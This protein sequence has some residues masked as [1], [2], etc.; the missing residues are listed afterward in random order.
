MN[1][2][3]R[4]LSAVAA[5]FIA[6]AFANAAGIGTFLPGG[7]STFDARVTTPEEFL[8]YGV[9]ERFAE[10]SDVTGYMNCL[11]GCSD[12]VSVKYFGRTYEKRPF[13]QVVITSAANQA[14]LEEIRRQHLLLTD[15]NASA[16]MDITRM[17]VVIDV[18]ASIHGNEAS[19]VNAMIPLA[20]YF[21]ACEDEVVKNFLDSAILIITPGQNPDGINRFAT[22]HNTGGSV[23]QICD[24]DSR[25]RSEGYPTSRGNHYWTDCNRDWL[26]VQYREGRNLVEMYL[27]WMPNVV[28][29]L[30]EQGGY[31]RGTYY[32]SPG[33]PNR[34]YHYIPQENQELTRSISRATAR[35]F[36]SLGVDYFTERG[37]DDFFIGKG[38][39]YGDI[40]GSVCLL[41]EQTS[42]RGLAKQLTNGYVMTLSETVRNQCI[43]SAAVA[44][45]ACALK[46]TLLSYS[47]EFF[48]RSALAAAGDPYEGY[49]F[50]TRSD[51]GLAFNF[52]SL[53]RSHDIEVFPVRG[54][55]NSYAVPFE[56][57]HYYKIKCLFEDITSFEDNVFYDVSTWTT[58]RGFNLDYRPVKRLPALGERIDRPELVGNVVSAGN[59]A[60]YRFTQKDYYTPAMMASLQR[61]GVVLSV[62]SEGN[63]YAPATAA[64]ED[65]ARRNG[66]DL[67]AVKRVPAEVT[68]VRKA[69]TAIILDG[70]TSQRWG[71][72]WNLLDDVYNIDHTLIDPGRVG[73]ADLSKYTSIIIYGK[74]GGKIKDTGKLKHWL[75]NGGTLILYS[76][77]VAWTK[78]L[79]LSPAKMTSGDKKFAGAILNAT[80]CNPSSP[81]VWGYSQADI[82]IF[83]G[84][85]AV[86][87]FPAGAET[88]IRFAGDCY[89]S[90]YVTPEKLSKFSR[91]PVVAT[92][93]AGKGCVVLIA[94]P[95]HFRSFWQG[96]SHILT[97]AV[98]FGDKI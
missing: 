97:N 18:M 37:Y 13:I 6:A 8:G 19:G 74:P 92:L 39:A 91:S 81:L 84:K 14:R 25:L 56:Q 3:L 88:V 35:A 49:L 34:T 26:N 45:R 12:R 48:R 31:K 46:D 21:A 10:W 57:K 87:E 75:E 44:L 95:L 77:A 42:S 20:Y 2:S 94:E 7:A 68:T 73:S 24:P 47:R 50:N 55:D 33:D 38:A 43:A 71:E 62:D 28:L 40:Q 64:V 27:H 78:R 67:K 17:P 69:R 9:A 23:N 65:A 1:N 72:I 80:I 93:R 5:A 36:D 85:D 41:H 30:H 22:F 58:A 86:A 52:I 82:D 96:T 15:I 76:S 54:E 32:F 29:D 63:A 79:G 61:E 16:Q 66:V 11:A 98:F 70:G 4:I 60:F 83:K 53:L 51:K 90:G 89:R 59:D